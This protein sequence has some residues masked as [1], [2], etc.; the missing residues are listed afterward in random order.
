MKQ[1]FSFLI[2]A[3][4]ATASAFA[5]VYKTALFGKTYNSK[6]VSAYNV[7]WAATNEGFTV[8]LQN[9]NN[10]NNGWEFVKGGSKNNASVATISTDQPI[11][12]AVS[13]VVV[14]VGA[15]T[16]ASVES[17]KLY[18]ASDSSFKT[19]IQTIDVKPASGEL[20]FVIT[21][22]TENLYYKFEASCKKSKNGVIQVNKLEYYD[23][24]DAPQKNV[25]SLVISGS[26][27]K[28]EY[29]AGEKFAPEGLVLTATY[30]DETSE[31]VTAKVSWAFD[32]A[33]IADTTKSVLVTATY[34]S[35]SASVTC[36]VTVM[37]IANTKETAY[38]VEEAIALIEAG[39]GLDTPVYV[40]GIVSKIVTAFNAKYG[41]VSF[42]V[43][44]DG[45]VSA[46]QFE[47]FR[48]QKDA[49]NLY[50]E[51]P[52]IA[53]GASVIGYGKLTKYNSTYEFAAGNYLVEYVAPSYPGDLNGD[54]VVDA[55]DLTALCEAIVN[56]DGS[57]T[58]EAG[59]LNDDGVLDVTDATI[60]V[61]LIAE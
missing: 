3:I 47:F 55:S 43:S 12:K 44:D 52:K 49:E 35:V 61:N 45:S 18:V 16:V 11:D 22:P 32:P 15:I 59:D 17:T 14:T 33:T 37:T 60:L 29:F 58:L 34:G 42:N 50:T 7:G 36:P 10:N 23:N 46:D 21:N 5:G 8:N 19:V 48:T 27:T 6:G 41:N 2:A 26:P 28:T 53:V 20:E 4:F 25:S 30:D 9:W 51:D 1:L 56:G 31:D 40:K 24:G 54:G 39:K 57:V 13:K 38:T